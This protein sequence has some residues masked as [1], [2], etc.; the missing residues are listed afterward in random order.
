MARRY[1]LHIDHD[2][3]QRAHDLLLEAAH[4]CGCK[5]SRFIMEQSLLAAEAMVHQRYEERAEPV[6][7]ME[8]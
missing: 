8:T 5:V 4:L 2:L 7:M 1:H 3:D 6:P